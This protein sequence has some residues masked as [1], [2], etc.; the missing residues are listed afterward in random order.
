M[1]GRLG[2]NDLTG[3]AALIGRQAEFSNSVAALAGT[4]PA[5][6][7]WSLPAPPAIRQQSEQPD[8]SLC[9]LIFMN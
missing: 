8:G 9:I 7:N 2:S 3:A 5:Q 4:A 1:L 6:W